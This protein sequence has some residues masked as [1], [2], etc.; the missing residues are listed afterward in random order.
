MKIVAS[1]KHPTS[2][3]RDVF[4]H[5]LAIVTLYVSVVS[6]ITLTFQYVN[7]LFPDP[8]GFYYQSILDS[9]RWST[10]ALLVMF[11]VYILMM[12]LIHRDFIKHPAMRE[13][14]IRK[15]LVYLTLFAAA[16]TI[17]ID[18]ITLIYNF[19]GGEL[20]LSFF[21]KIAIVLAVAATVFGYYFWDL[22]H[23]KKRNGTSKIF[24]WVTSVVILGVIIG[25]FF[26]VGSPGKQRM[27]RFDERRTGDL[28]TIQ[29]EIINYWTL[30]KTL[31]STLDDL[32]N[33]I[34]GFTPPKDPEAKTAYEYNILSPLSFE[35]CAI[36]NLPSTNM[37]GSQYFDSPKM[38][39]SPYASDQNWEHK[40]GRVC[41]ERTI[42][43]ELYKPYPAGF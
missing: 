1:K 36:F 12:W 25:G 30:K 27:I 29:W 14:T 42:D 28:Q 10:S 23:D 18:I 35:L 37:Q 7:V 20:T 4:M 17:I 31:P 2:G 5:L 8:L 15:W 40:I 38:A 22:R 3:P 16:L 13:L 24:G 6:F 26:I 33:S 11:A 41:F 21:L 19:L 9:I 43:P 39:S 34:S 32:Q